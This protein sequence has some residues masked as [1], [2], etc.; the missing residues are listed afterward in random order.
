MAIKEIKYSDVEQR[1]QTIKTYIDEASAKTLTEAGSYTDEQVSVA[2]AYTDEKIG[3]IPAPDIPAAL[4]Q[5]YEAF[6]I[7]LPQGTNNNLEGEAP[8]WVEYHKTLWEGSEALTESDSG[9]SFVS[10]VVL[11]WDAPRG[12]SLL[13]TVDGAEK[14]LKFAGVQSSQ[15]TSWATWSYSENGTVAIQAKSFGRRNGGYW[16]NTSTVDVYCPSGSA[17]IG[18][19]MTKV[20]YGRKQ[21]SYILQ[22]PYVVLQ[23]PT[24]AEAT[25]FNTMCQN[26]FKQK[27]K[28]RFT[29][30]EREI[31]ANYVNLSEELA[32]T[33]YS[34]GDSGLTWLNVISDR[35]PLKVGSDV[36]DDMPQCI[37]G[38]LEIE[39]TDTDAVKECV[40]TKIP[41]ESYTMRI[42]DFAIEEA[43]A[44]DYYFDGAFLFPDNTQLQATFTYRT[45][46]G[47]EKSINAKTRYGA[48]DGGEPSW[49]P[50]FD[51]SELF[52]QSANTVLAL[53]Y[54]NM[55]V[56]NA[57]M[58]GRPIT[59]I[60]ISDTVRTF[61]DANDEIIMSAILALVPTSLPQTYVKKNIVLASDG[62]TAD[63]SLPIDTTARYGIGSANE[64]KIADGDFAYL[65]PI[66]TEKA[67]QWRADYSSGPVGSGTAMTNMPGVKAEDSENAVTFRWSEDFGVRVEVKTDGLYAY[68]SV[69]GGVF[70]KLSADVAK[71]HQT[72]TDSDIVV[73]SE[74][75]ID[76]NEDNG[77]IAG[78]SGLQRELSKSNGSLVLI[79]NK[80]PTSAIVGTMSIMSTSS[81]GVAMV[82]GIISGEATSLT[83]TASNGDAYVVSVSDEGQ[84]VLTKQ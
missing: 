71:Y 4:P 2:K 68:G 37:K 24:E 79:A 57:A 6:E 61:A 9:A 41:G 65:L 52:G 29:L 5:K 48:F 36:T 72:I 50:I 80:Q 78:Q 35:V 82:R 84:I 77:K 66:T 67:A 70:E 60:T 74:V 28:V 1:A 18:K 81:E 25:R 40:Y 45:A 19:A 30:T 46:A 47:V 20:R 10:N 54:T 73:K 49:L 21:Y 14:E 42:G 53:F 32:T 23:R 69:R 7:Q 59:T 26:L 51:L 33:S 39:Y 27:A 64:A 58:G 83:L 44:L 55:A 63:T 11:Y 16:N 22:N 17:Y 76:L 31:E 3:S 75:T 38:I 8:A 34:E 15:G 13:I 12:Y 43:S 56:E 62:W